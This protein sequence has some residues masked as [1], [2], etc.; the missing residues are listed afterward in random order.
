VRGRAK[1]GNETG[2]Y[3]IGSG[4]DPQALHV[5]I[6][7][8]ATGNGDGVFSTVAG[9]RLIQNRILRNGR[10]GVHLS[11]SHGT[12]EGNRIANNQRNGIFC[13]DCSSLTV[14]DNKVVGNGGDGVLVDIHH[15]SNGPSP[16]LTQQPG[17][18]EQA[19]GNQCRRR[20]IHGV[21]GD[22]HGESGSRQ[23]GGPG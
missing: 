1:S 10:D 21:P 19:D 20:S 6:D 13:A 8:E 23:P 2:F 12:L 4:G 15:N 11:E 16:A 22:D 5:L 14:T 7:N 9:V 3:L 17:H 18:A